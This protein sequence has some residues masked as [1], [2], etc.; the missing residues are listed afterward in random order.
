ME[1]SSYTE[2]LIFLPTFFENC[3]NI[4]N[5]QESIDKYMSPWGLRAE[6]SMQEPSEGNEL[7]DKLALE[8]YETCSVI[9]R[10]C[11]PYFL[12]PPE[13]R[14]PVPLAPTDPHIE[15]ELASLPPEERPSVSLAPTDPRLD[16]ELAN[17]PPEEKNRRK[18]TYELHRRM[19]EYLLRIGD[20]PYI[21][22]LREATK[23][24]GEVLQKHNDY[25]SSREKYNEALKELILKQEKLDKDSKEE[26][27]AY[28]SM[29]I[30][31]ANYELV[32]Q[33]GQEEGRI[34]IPVEGIISPEVILA[35][36]NSMETP[37]E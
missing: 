15:A 32:R 33:R 11:H 28:E 16:V 30:S 25:Q 27:L 34:P 31:S 23:S 18:V 21:E 9:K 5:I 4:V 6:G 24:H 26:R 20:T 35:M 10:H 3:R 8:I 19:G 37:T 22:C 1:G 36:Y 7:I 29:S 2:N 14:S 12:L 13:A 17:L